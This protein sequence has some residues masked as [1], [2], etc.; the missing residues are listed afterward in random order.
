MLNNLE[1]AKQQCYEMRTIGSDF[2]WIT[3]NSYYWMQF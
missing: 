3:N 2:F 1:N